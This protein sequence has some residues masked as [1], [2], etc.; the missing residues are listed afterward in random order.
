MLGSGTGAAGLRRGIHVTIRAPLFAATLA[1]TGIVF[2][3]GYAVAQP[4][5]MTREGVEPTRFTEP[6]VHSKSLPAIGGAP[7]SDWGVGILRKK[8]PVVGEPGPAAAI[9]VVREFQDLDGRIRVGFERLTPLELSPEDRARWG[10]CFR[11]DEVE[12]LL[13][14]SR[15]ELLVGLAAADLGPL[16]DAVERELDGIPMPA[17]LT[18]ETGPG[19]SEASL[20]PIEQRIVALLGKL[21]KRLA[22]GRRDLR[23][24]STPSARR[25]LLTHERNLARPESGMTDDKR[26]VWAGHYILRV[27]KSTGEDAC[28]CALNLWDQPTARVTC[29]PGS[30][31]L[32]PAEC[33]RE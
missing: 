22:D 30:E 21:Q 32:A 16:R 28:L 14:Q 9:T 23:I 7:K 27:F 20:V 19:A 11:K 17:Y 8:T 6:P 33:V 2:P 31:A 29:A 13:A 26:G 10:R 1:V 5:P 24:V 3:A 25:F 4:V 15:G 12:Q 18:F